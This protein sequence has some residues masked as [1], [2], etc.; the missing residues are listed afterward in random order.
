M[1]CCPLRVFDRG[2]D[3]LVRIVSCCCCFRSLTDLQQDLGHVTYRPVRQSANNVSTVGHLGSTYAMVTRVASA[4]NRLTTVITATGNV[5]ANAHRNDVLSIVVSKLDVTYA[6]SA[7]AVR[8]DHGAGRRR[9]SNLCDHQPFHA[10]ESRHTSAKGMPAQNQW[11]GWEAP[12]EKRHNIAKRAVKPSSRPFKAIVSSSGGNNFTLY[13][14]GHVTI[15]IRPSAKRNV[16]NQACS[17][18]QGQRTVAAY[19]MIR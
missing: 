10:E 13:V 4:P 18:F 11:I 7:I 8:S 2:S 1:R 5:N 3:R 12:S 6:R 15:L 9:S 14:C 19:R 17:D 16:T